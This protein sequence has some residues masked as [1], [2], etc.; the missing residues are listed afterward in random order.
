MLHAQKPSFFHY[1]GVYGL[2]TFIDKLFRMLLKFLILNM[3]NPLVNN[4]IASLNTVFQI[5]APAI[6]PPPNP[7]S[8]WL[9]MNSEA[10]VLEN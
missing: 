4:K 5:L 1:D 7:I 2:Y 3:T 9:F 8:F 6:Q 10:V